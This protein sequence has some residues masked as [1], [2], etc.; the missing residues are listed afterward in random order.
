MNP[1]RSPVN[2]AAI[3]ALLSDLYEQI[4]ALQAEN[5]RLRQQLAGAPAPQEK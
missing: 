5:D 1:P 3:L 4:A 2:P